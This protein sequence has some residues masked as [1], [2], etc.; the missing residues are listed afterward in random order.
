MEGINKKCKMEERKV[1]WKEGGAEGDD[2]RKEKKVKEKSR[3]E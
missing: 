3:R 1:K 2:S